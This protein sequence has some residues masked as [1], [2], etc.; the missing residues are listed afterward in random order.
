V[1]K[2]IILSVIALA[3]CDTGARKDLPNEN[4][5]LIQSDVEVYV[6]P[7][8]FPNLVHRCTNTTGMWSTT[9]RYVW[10]V[11][12]DPDCGGTGRVLVLD[13]VHRTTSGGEG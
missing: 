8:Q 11:Y 1:K 7:D 3:A 5:N 6:N 4:Q 10:I 2:A 9:D 12:N 13:N